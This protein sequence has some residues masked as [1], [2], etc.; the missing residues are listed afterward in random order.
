MQQK[1]TCSVHRDAISKRK[2]LLNDRAD[3]RVARSE[4]SC[5][6]ELRI[7]TTKIK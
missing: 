2:A 5:S 1:Y 4:F 7:P 3:L 6:A